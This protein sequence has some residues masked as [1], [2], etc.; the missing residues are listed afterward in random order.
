MRVLVTGLSGF[1]GSA[2]DPALVQRGHEVRRLPRRD[3]SARDFAGGDAVVHLANV[4]DPR[5]ARAVL[6]EVNVRGTRAAAELAAQAGVRRFIYISSVKADIGADHYGRTKLLAEQA[7]AEVS[8]RTR[9][10]MVVLRPPILYGAGV[11]GSFYALLHAIGKGW[12]LPFGSVENRRSLLYVENL[13]SAIALCLERDEARGRTFVLSD[14]PALSTPELCSRLGEALGR[15]ARLF[16]FPVVLLNA[17]P[18]MRALTESLEI[19]DST[20][21]RELG[22]APP[23][24]VHEA[25]Q[26]TARWYRSR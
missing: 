17:I 20:I 21:R 10:E 4:A 16:S 3:W 12:P 13:A 26:Q 14:G 8:A 11:R 1:V 23:F 24:S 15:P 6:W 22:W 9:M 5:A 7:L 19:E 2:L 25:M 18:R